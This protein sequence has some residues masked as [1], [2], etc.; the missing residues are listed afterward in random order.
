LREKKQL[1]KRG[2][3]RAPVVPAADY[4]V[5]NNTLRKTRR[6]TA[7]VCC[8]SAVFL[9]RL[10]AHKHLRVPQLISFS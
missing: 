8:V 1:N 9:L 2:R 3:A 5:V 4:S 6:T 10:I 7:T